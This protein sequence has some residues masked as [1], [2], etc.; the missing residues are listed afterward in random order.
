[1]NKRDRTP[2]LTDEPKVPAQ[3]GRRPGTVHRLGA[4]TTVRLATAGPAPVTVFVAGDIDLACADE[5]A[6]VLCTAL[7]THPQGIRLDLTSV[8]FL[9]CCG[10]RALMVAR[11]SAERHGRHF[12]LGPHSSSVARLLELTG[13]GSLL[14][15]AR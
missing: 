6:R 5:L 10:L 12:G 7:D 13:T 3:V 11:A 4:Y 14:A 8:R 2:S 15:A 1:M 9:D